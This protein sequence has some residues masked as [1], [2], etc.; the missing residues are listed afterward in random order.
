MAKDNTDDP[1]RN[2]RAV[3]GNLS[4]QQ[5]RL[6][7]VREEIRKRERQILR[8]QATIGTLRYE[9]NNLVVQIREEHGIEVPDWIKNTKGR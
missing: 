2:V 8:L 7:S 9:E 3:K 4:Q 5:K 1:L 6:A